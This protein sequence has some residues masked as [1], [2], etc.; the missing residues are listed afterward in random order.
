MPRESLEN[1]LGNRG[2]NSWETFLKCISFNRASRSHAK[3]DFS[4][5]SKSS[6]NTSVYQLFH[7]LE[8]TGRAW[9]C[10]WSSRGHFRLLL[11]IFWSTW[12]VLLAI[13]AAHCSVQTA[14]SSVQTAN[15]SVQRA[16][17]S[18]QTANCGVQ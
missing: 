17:S 10:L 2:A 5:P 7:T 13:P 6:E 3:T 4:K 1:P 8:L 14:T 15:S 11:G 16:I 12:D 9:G 18:A